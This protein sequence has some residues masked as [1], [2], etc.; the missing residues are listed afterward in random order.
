VRLS[1]EGLRRLAPALADALM[2]QRVPATV[3]AL[4]PEDADALLAAREA[5]QRWRGLVDRMPPAELLDLVLD[6]SAYLVET[7]GP[8]ARQAR[9]NLKKMRAMIRR[10]QNRG[11]T[12]LDRIVSHLDRLALGD[13][14]NAVIDASD[15][16]SLMTVHAAK[17]LEFPVVFIVNLA[18][19]TGT[20]RPPIRVVTGDDEPSVAVGDFQSSGDEDQPSREREETKRLLYVALTRARDRLYLSSVL[21]DGQLKPGRGS[22]AEVMPIALQDRFAEASGAASVEWTASSGTVHTLR[23][24]PRVESGGSKEQDPPYESVDSNTRVA[25]NARVDFDA[26]SDLD[27]KRASVADTI[28]GTMLVAP[29]RDAGLSSSRMI[30]TL[31]H[32][33]LQRDGLRD[34]VADEWIIARLAMLLRAGEAQ[35]IDDQP[36]LLARAAASYRAFVANTDVRNLYLSGTPF[37]EVPFSLDA[38]GAI[39]RGSIDCLIRH[40]RSITVLEFKTGAHQPEHDAQADLYR[41]AAA[42]LFPDFVV[43]S[44]LVYAKPPVTR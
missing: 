22:L 29:S 12:T 41:R 5:S 31:V 20:R 17:G 24:C 10:L 40:D 7:R 25:S 26:L 33:L 8:R 19:G 39:V 1:D 43:S 27:A 15:A 6:E 44:R 34:E 16:V 11:Y 38:G 14:A 32:R 36:A 4:E 9:E 42:A 37:H 13:E 18:R 23:V 2:T 35:D 3:S 28:A 21:K 30:G